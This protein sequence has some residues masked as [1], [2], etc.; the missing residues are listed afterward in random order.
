MLSQTL[1]GDE[2]C[3]KVLYNHGIWIKSTRGNA[4]IKLNIVRCVL[5]LTVSRNL[6]VYFNQCRCPIYYCLKNIVRTRQTIIRSNLTR[7]LS[8]VVF[9]HMLW[10][11]QTYKHSLSS[12]ILW[13]SGRRHQLAKREVAGSILSLFIYYHLECFA[14]FPLLTALRS[15]YKWNQVWHSSKVTGA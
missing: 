8:C 12:V 11:C 15:P 5:E 14:C 1:T 13:P 7:V 2:L 3:L 6:R 4:C 9:I 10:L